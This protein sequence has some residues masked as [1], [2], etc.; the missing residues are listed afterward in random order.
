MR[1][2]MLFG[3]ALTFFAVLLVAV[4]SFHATRAD[5]D[6]GRGD[7]ALGANEPIFGSWLIRVAGQPDNSPT[8][9]MANFFPATNR[10]GNAE[11]AQAAAFRSDAKGPL[12]KAGRTG[13]V[14]HYNFRDQHFHYAETAPYAIIATETHEV[15]AEYHTETDT[16]SGVARIFVQDLDGNITS[17]FTVEVTGER[18]EMP[19]F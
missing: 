2:R 9:F 15:V 4:V 13:K 8:R 11:I 10:F 14:I 5:A 19:G 16:L 6:L 3:I 17:D 1:K 18:L 7:T 12:T